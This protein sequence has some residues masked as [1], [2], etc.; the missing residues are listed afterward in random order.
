MSPAVSG[1]TCAAAVTLSGRT[2][3]RETPSLRA[4]R[5]PEGYRIELSLRSQQRPAL[6]PSTGTASG[7]SP[8]SLRSDPAHGFHTEKVLLPVWGA[9]SF[10]LIHLWTQSVCLSPGAARHLSFMFAHLV[11]HLAGRS[12]GPLVHCIMWADLPCLSQHALRT[13]QGAHAWG[14]QAPH[15]PGVSEM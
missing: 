14:F 2:E 3:A 15:H 13:W 4:H 9:P 1:P 6:P 8:G 7:T 10:V 5:A 11:A 12:A